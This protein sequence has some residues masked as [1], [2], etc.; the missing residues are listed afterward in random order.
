MNTQP[1]NLDGFLTYGGSFTANNKSFIN[2]KAQSITNV[3]FI[4]VRVTFES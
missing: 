2:F 3:K 4:N 1:K